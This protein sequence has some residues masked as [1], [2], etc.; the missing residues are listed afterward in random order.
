MTAA[1]PRGCR[2]YTTTRDTISLRVPL[3]QFV[4][5]VERGVIAC[6]EGPELHRMILP[7]HV[8]QTTKRHYAGD[9]HGLRI[10]LLSDHGIARLEFLQE[11]PSRASTV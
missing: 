8:V 3:Q 11:E 4:I 1:L 7:P 2:S 6:F 5:C 10:V 9:S